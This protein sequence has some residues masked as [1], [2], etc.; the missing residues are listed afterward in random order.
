MAY[1][2]G[3]GG[4]LKVYPND[5]RESPVKSYGHILGCG[6]KAVDRSRGSV[7]AEGRQKDIIQK[8]LEGAF[9]P[10]ALKALAQ[11]D[12]ADALAK[13]LKAVLDEEASSAEARA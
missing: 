12:P 11:P 4:H 6:E 8:A 1:C 2:P 13:A 5:P 9:G 3:C 10:D 7:W